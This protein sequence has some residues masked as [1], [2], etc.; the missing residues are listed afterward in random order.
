MY[1]KKETLTDVIA[2]VE[3]EVKKQLDQYQ[4]NER[5]KQ[6]WKDIKLSPGYE[7]MLNHISFVDL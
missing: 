7:A 2:R 6:A 3:L 4:A 5:Y 1:Y